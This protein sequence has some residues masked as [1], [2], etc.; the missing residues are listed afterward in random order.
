MERRKFSGKM[1]FTTLYHTCCLILPS[2][3]HVP[4]P[5]HGHQ[6]NN[7]STSYDV[8]QS[9][10]GNEASCEY[11]CCLQQATVH[12]SMKLAHCVF[13]SYV[14]SFVLITSLHMFWTIQCAD[15]VCTER[16]ARRTISNDGL[17]TFIIF[18]SKHLHLFDR[19]FPMIQFRLTHFL[20]QKKK[21]K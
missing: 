4:L 7:A 20:Y 16:I 3:V 13:Y 6:H 17:Y 8:H 18:F 15:N 11:V 19:L 1:H 9:C 12:K 21:L 14:L 2:F 5:V 10:F